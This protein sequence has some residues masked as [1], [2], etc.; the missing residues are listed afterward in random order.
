MPTISKES[1]CV[2]LINVFTVDPKNQA[3]LVKLLIDATTTTI[4]HIDGFI[5]ATFHRSLDGTKV[6]AY[7]QWRS[8]EHYQAMRVNSRAL[9]TMEQVLALATFDGGMYEV[10]DTFEV[11]T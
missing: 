5:S 9:P 10:V 3:Q 11:E 1:N 2:T 4:R 8:A 7:A 6:T